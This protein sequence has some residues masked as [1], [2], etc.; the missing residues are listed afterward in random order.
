MAGAPS[1][2]RRTPID[3]ERVEPGSAAA[4]EAASPVARCFTWTIYAAPATAVKRFDGGD[5][6]DGL[7]VHSCKSRLCSCRSTT[8]EISTVESANSTDGCTGVYP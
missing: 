7:F 4:S 3:H 5:R 2:A 6:T 8:D 1:F